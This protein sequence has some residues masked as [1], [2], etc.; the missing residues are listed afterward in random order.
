MANV[1]LSIVNHGQTSTF[2]TISSPPHP[3]KALVHRDSALSDSLPAGQVNQ[4]T[5]VK[6][7][8]SSSYSASV[9]KLSPVPQPLQLSRVKLW[10]HFHLAWER[11]WIRLFNM[12]ILLCSTA[13]ARQATSFQSG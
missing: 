11:Y 6:W 10:A 4:P 5:K 7:C 9:L 1:K 13:E 12:L 2:Q 3:V 8:H